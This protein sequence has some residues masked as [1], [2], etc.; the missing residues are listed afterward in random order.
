M[1]ALYEFA[2]PWV[3]RVLKVPHEPHPPAGSPGSLKVFR[4]GRASYQLRLAL[5]AL[6]QVGVLIAFVLGLIFLHGWVLDPPRFLEKVGPFAFFAQ[7]PEIVQRY[8]IDLWILG[9]EIAG[10]TLALLQIPFTYAMVRM[11]YEYRWYLVT[12]RSLRI[13]TGLTRVRETTFSFANIQQIVVNQGPLQRILGLADVVVTTA[14]GGGTPAVGPEHAHKGMPEPMHRGVFHN[15]DNAAEIRD[16]IVERLRRL[17]SAGLG[18]PD[19]PDSTPHPADPAP[20][21]A[22]PA[23]VTPSA[24][25]VDAALEFRAETRALRELIERGRSA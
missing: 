10:L 8:R 1:N 16:L 21:T 25:L 13:R 23:P 17:K 15:V 19:D 9:L 3:L 18:D 4:A 22:A 14:G 24:A 6:R 5:W 20:A 2:R 11:D 7:H 12:D